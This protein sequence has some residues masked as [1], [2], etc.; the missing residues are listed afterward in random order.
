MPTAMVGED[1]GGAVDN[2]HAA[3][4][5][6]I[7]FEAGDLEAV[8]NQLTGI[9]AP[10]RARPVQ[11]LVKYTRVSRFVKPVPVGPPSLIRSSLSNSIILA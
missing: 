8:G 7:I 3:T 9:H 4:T 11:R 1:I 10:L 6:E 5:D 2:I